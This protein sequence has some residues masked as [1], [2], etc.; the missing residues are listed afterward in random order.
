[1]PA[2]ELVMI[3]AEPEVARSRS[4][5]ADVVLR[6]R[7]QLTADRDARV[8]EQEIEPAAALCGEIGEGR[9]P[10]GAIAHVHRI[11]FGAGHRG[12]RL[13]QRPGIDVGQ[14]DQPAVGRQALR[15]RQADARCAAGDECRLR[16]HVPASC[17][18]DLC[19]F[20]PH[21]RT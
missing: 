12:L 7:P 20:I 5:A 15:D 14:P 3:I 18:F 2:A 4:C 8:V 1:M 21:K 10:G 13:G 11:G 9:L 6:H 19:D 17:S 16:R